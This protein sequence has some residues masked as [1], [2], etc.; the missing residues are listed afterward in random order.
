MTIVLAI[1]ILYFIVMFAI[2]YWANTK[3]K[4][5][6]DFLVAGQSLGFFVMAIASFSS[7]QSGFGMI[8][9]TANTNAWG[10][11]AVVGAALLVP[12][13]FALA[14]F[15]LGARLHRVARA[16]EVYSIPDIIRVRYPN[17]SAHMS[18]SIAMFIGS[19]AYMTAQVTALGVIMSLIFGISLTVGAIIG[20]AIVAAYTIAGGMLAAVWTDFIQGLLMIVMAI[21]A[22][23][24]A[25]NTVGGWS[26]MLDTI[27]KNDIGFLKIDATQPMTWIFGF[28]FLA[29]LGTAA[30]P[31]LATKFLMLKSGSQLRWGSLVAAVGYSVTTLFALSIGLATRA[32]TFEGR[33]PQFDNADNTT[34]WF[35][36]NMTTPAFAGFAL[37]GLLAAIMSSASSFITIGAS[38]LV[39]DLTS[40]LGKVVHREL[41]WNRLASAFVVLCSLVFAL[42]LTQVVFLLGAIGW[43]AFASAVFAPVV[44]G[45][46]WKRAT[47]MATTIAVS[48]GVLGNLVLTILTSEEIITIPTYMQDGAMVIATAAVLFVVISLLFPS[49]GSR[50]G[51]ASAYG[52]NA[53]SGTGALRGGAAVKSVAVK[54]FDRTDV[55]VLIV[56]LAC[57]ATAV[58]SLFDTWQALYYAIPVIAFV[59]MLFGAL[60]STDKWSRA[61]VVLISAFSAVLI[62]LFIL[63]H[64]FFG[65]S[66]MLGGLPTTTAVFVYVIWPWTAVGAPL[67]YAAVHKSWLMRDMEGPVPAAENVSV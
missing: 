4:G 54:G 43:A 33:A 27:A 37:A 16:H 25:T 50:D 2:G 22:F 11:Q 24:I 30:Q 34:T 42:Y 66:A 56:T 14:W 64:A 17:R 23:F 39:R 40:S 35:L 15:I 26:A 48:F 8:G 63:A 49:Q 44:F 3:M 21:A 10:I 61:N 38:S 67:V 13:G 45:L 58:G 7:I 60:N 36:D 57:L 29:I 41:M 31:Q 59:M 28:I 6:K 32:L 12:L 18:M 46:Y 53:N 20:S 55:L 47:G 52:V 62:G 5:A 19:V 65:S 9:H 51:F 1:V